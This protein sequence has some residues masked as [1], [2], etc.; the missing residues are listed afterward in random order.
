ME[1]GSVCNAN[2]VTYSLH[3]GLDFCYYYTYGFIYVTFISVS[4]LA[5][6]EL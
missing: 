6:N 5:A 3:T 2:N 1:L 4:R